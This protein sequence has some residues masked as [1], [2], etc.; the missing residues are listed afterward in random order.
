MDFRLKIT[1][2]IA[3]LFLL[4]LVFKII[5]TRTISVR[6]ALMW[7]IFT[8]VLLSFVVFPDFVSNVAVAMHFK[9]TSNFIFVIVI[10]TLVLMLLS[11]TIFISKQNEKVQILT[12][13]VAILKTKTN[14]HINEVT[15][16]GK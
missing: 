15:K 3:T 2:L 11:L 16:K 1:L 10:A 14:V 6:Y 13:E 8:I 4:S 7:I 12:Q 5:K 9:T